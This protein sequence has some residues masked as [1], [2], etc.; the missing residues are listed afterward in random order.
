MNSVIEV[1][2]LRRRYGAV[3]AVAGIDL[4]VRPGEVVALLGPNG[5][6]KTTTVEILTG[7]RRR[8]E[9]TVTVLGTDPQDGDSRWRARLGAV[10]QGTTPVLE[11]TVHELL[12]AQAACYPSPHPVEVVMTDFEL[13]GLGNRRVKVLSGGERR[14]LDVAL[15][16]VGGPELLFLDEP[17]T[18][19]DPEVRRRMWEIVRR[20]VERGTTIVL[21]THY[22]AEAETLADRVIVLREGR[23]VAEGR[24]DE[25]AAATGHKVT[26]RFRRPDPDRPLPALPGTEV[27]ERDGCVVIETDEPTA[28]V[29]A[30]AAWAGG[31]LAEL[32]VARPDL[33]DVYLRLIGERDA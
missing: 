29:A 18:G 22:L 7:L 33:E 25:L 6:G 11:L 9:G 3:E 1:H 27:V 28:V 13:D 2:G 4:D 8:D 16:V 19:L 23:I 30:L 31:E 26:V 10:L 5:A 14:R 15:A 17:T 20:L 21:T 32:V 24:P 12:D